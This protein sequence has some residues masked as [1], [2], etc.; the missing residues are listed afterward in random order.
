MI[1]DKYGVNEEYNK[2]D[3]TYVL[4]DV[5]APGTFYES[6][7][8]GGGMDQIVYDGAR[9][10]NIDLR[11]ATLKYEQGGGGNVSYAFG[12]YGGF[13]I[14]NGVTVENARSG[15]GDDKLTGNAAANKLEGGEGDDT[16]AGGAGNDTLNGGAGNDTADFSD[17]DGYFRLDLDVATAQALGAAGADTLIGIENV[18]GGSGANTIYGS[19]ANNRL[20]GGAGN[21]YLDGRGG[22]DIIIGGAGADQLNGRAG[23]DRFYYEA[24]TDTGVGSARD[25]I[26]DF[27]RGFDKIDLS[28]IDAISGTTANDAFTF[29]GSAAFS[30]KAGE[31]RY[32]SDAAGTIIAGDVIG[33][34]I[35]VFEI[36]LTNKVLPTSA[37]FVL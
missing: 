26:G 33:D 15:A 10:A 37:D 12:V 19:A 30:K 25:R 1:Q 8:D 23:W 20:E 27:T 11:A 34:G 5:N 28:S 35:A 2:G 36:Q 18:I 4:K 13:T 14:A 29:V 31:L 3:N 16:L 32:Y 17:T 24:I 7:W 21:D 22:D 6:I 9:D